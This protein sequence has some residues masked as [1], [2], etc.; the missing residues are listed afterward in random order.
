MVRSLMS[1]LPSPLAS[2]G[3][4]TI[5][6]GG[7]HAAP[8][9]IELHVIG[10]VGQLSGHPQTAAQARGNVAPRQPAHHGAGRL[11]G[12]DS[13]QAVRLAQVVVQRRCAEGVN[14]LDLADVGAVA[15]VEVGV[16]NAD[17]VD[18]RVGTA[19]RLAPVDG[20]GNAADRQ[21]ISL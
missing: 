14:G 15:A 12:I 8:I 11:V 21:R 7:L 13:E 19:Q 6:C 4:W 5:D 9:G 10:P 3:F 2:P 17:V 16:E 1:T 20:L 18:R